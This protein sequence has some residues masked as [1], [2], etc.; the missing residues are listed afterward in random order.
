[1][2]SEK[3]G[4]VYS[5]M[6]LEHDSGPGHP[7]RPARLRAIVGALEKSGLLQRMTPVTFGPA[8]P[9]T[10]EMVHDPAYVGLVRMACEKDLGWVGSMDTGI[11]TRSYEV[12]RLAAGGIISACDEVMAGRVGRAFC[13]VRPPGHH[14]EAYKAMGF[15]LFNNV[16]LAAQHLIRHHGL[17]RVAIVDFD[18]HHGNGTQH[19]FEE[20]SDVLFISLHEHP[21][22]LYPGT[23]W[24]GETGRGAGEGYTINLPMPPGAGDED[25]RDAFRDS[26]VPAL[27]RYRPEFL[28]VSAGFDAAAGE[29]I[30][31][32]SLSPAAFTFMTGELA[33]VSRRHCGGRLISTLE[34]GYE[35]ENLER[36]VPAHVKVLL[37]A[38]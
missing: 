20:R 1:M 22:F 29:T 9:R 18:V 38:E 26:V 13:A 35:L 25:Y 34:G 3:V 11:C 10:L 7:E 31:H 19:F 16:A 2:N 17:T 6:F 14:A 5:N 36:C 27:D 21:Q 28:L 30:A 24:P 37:G 33:A 8:E 12:A 15:C 32:L 4:W 23:G